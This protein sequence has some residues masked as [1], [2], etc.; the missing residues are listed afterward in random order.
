MTEEGR[1]LGEQ[2]RG[3]GRGSSTGST[4]RKRETRR[5][6]STTGWGAW[7]PG[8]AYPRDLAV[9]T[10]RVCCRVQPEGPW[11]VRSPSSAPDAATSCTMRRSTPSTSFLRELELSDVVLIGHSDG[12][13]SLDLH[14]GAP[15]GLG[16]APH[17]TTRIRRAETMVGIEQGSN[18]SRPP[19]SRTGQIP[20]GP[21]GTFKAWSEIWLDP[22][23]RDWNI[24]DSLP[25][26]Q[27]PVLLVQALD[28]EY[29]TMAQLDAIERGV[30][31]PVERLMI[32]E[33]GHSPHSP[34]PTRCGRIIQLRHA[35]PGPGGIG[36]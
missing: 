30:S 27:C 6:F 11:L 34:T 3:R 18:A 35:G 22:A 24:E 25:N 20:P 21:R 17:R 28:D 10:G 36:R 13:S 7:A 9:A 8:R 33:G 26:I 2:A 16:S 32:P 23:F 31:G 29:G 1:L 4:S 15:V 12:A 19:I 14:R 5:C